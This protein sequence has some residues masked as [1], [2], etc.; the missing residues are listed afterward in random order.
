[1]EAGAAHSGV[2]QAQDVHPDRLRAHRG[3]RGRHRDEVLRIHRD[4]GRHRGEG[5]SRRYE[6]HQGARRPAVT[7]EGLLDQ[8]AA[9]WADPMTTPVVQV[10]VES[11]GRSLQSEVQA[12]A[13]LL[14]PA[15]QVRAAALRGAALSPVRDSR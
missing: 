15:L 5:R 11:G 13:A 9:E 10:A 12:F 14:L 2:H 6:V 8:G 3:R 1:M 4:E 7:P